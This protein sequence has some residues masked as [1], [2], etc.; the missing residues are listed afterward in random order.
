MKVCPSVS[1]APKPCPEGC[2]TKIR[3]RARTVSPEPC[4]GSGGTD[5]L[6]GSSFDGTKSKRSASR[7][8]CPGDTVQGPKRAA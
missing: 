3:E 1:P 7:E 6:R 5:A 4:Q 2:G 8:A